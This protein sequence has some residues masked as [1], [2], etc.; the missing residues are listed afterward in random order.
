[1]QKYQMWKMVGTDSVYFMHMLIGM[2]SDI[3]EFQLMIK[4]QVGEL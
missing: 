4:T 2:D 1:M 3:S